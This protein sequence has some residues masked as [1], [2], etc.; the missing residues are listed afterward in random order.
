VELRDLVVTPIWLIIIYVL[1]YVIR[2]YVTDQ[3]NRR[4]F[5]PALTIKII[6]A[7]A[8]GF[9]YQFYYDGGDTFYYHTHGSRHIWN[10][11]LDDLAIGIDL[12]FSDGS[13]VSGTYQYSIKIEYYNDPQSFFIVRIAAFLDLFTYSSYSATAVLFSLI[14]FIGAWLMFITFY[15]IAPELHRWE[16]ISCLFIP[17]VIIWGSGILKDTITLS[18]LGVALYCLFKVAIE[19]KIS[20][21]YLLGLVLSV[22]IIFSIKKYILLCFAPVMMIWVFTQIFSGIKSL[23]FKLLFVPIAIVPVLFLSYF[24]VSKIGE[25]DQR[26]SV[27]KLARTAQITAYDIRYGWGAR[28]G[29]G[30]G[31]T[32]GELDGTWQSMA[33]LAPAAIVVS[34]FRPFLWEIRNPLMAL[35]ALESLTFL[36]L[37]L[38]V[39]YKSGSRILFYLQKPEVILCLG[40]A[41]VFAFAVG[42]ST[43]NFGSLSRY[44]IPLLPFYAMG[45]GFIYHYSNKDKNVG[46]LESTE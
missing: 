27:T 17:S 25:N 30:S 9:I 43:F 36:I 6:G 18:A 28:K 33:R 34:L 5:F 1:A 14:S 41:V 2:P 21:L 15:R 32:L 23:V 35:S 31:Y 8:V 39:F 12:L 10:A 46:A 26:Y 38:Y 3:V 42:V 7:L 4:Y 16:A 22:W 40:F 13:H 19:R 11:F 29:E 20:L 24:I 37:T 45:L 44:K